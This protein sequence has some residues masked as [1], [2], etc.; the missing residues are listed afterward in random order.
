MLRK[1]TF[2][3]ILAVIILFSAIPLS[4]CGN[5][6][7][8][9]KDSAAPSAFPAAE[10]SEP[11]IET[12]APSAAPTVCP[13]PTSA[14]D[15]PETPT[16]EPGPAYE[17]NPHLYLPILAPE[18]PQ[19]HWDSLYNLCDALRAGETTFECSSEEAYKWATDPVTLVHLF[20]AAALKIKGQSG[21]GSP[22]FE[23]GVGK[24][25][26]QMPAEEFV[27]RQARFEEL[28]ADVL[29]TY[30]EADDNDFEK[31]LKLYDYMESNYTYNYDFIDSMP[32]GHVYYTIMARS[33]QCID[34]GSVY[35]FFLLQAGVEALL[36]SGTAPGM[37]HAW[38]YLVI[39]GNGY[40]SD[41]TWALRAADEPLGLHYFLMS[42][43]LRAEYG[44]DM[45]ELTAPLIP[46]YWVKFSSIELTADND[47]YC[48]PFGSFLV[49]LDE[50][51]KIVRYMLFDE[52]LELCY[53]RN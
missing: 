33:G 35:A 4:G 5:K 17:F 12:A 42:T 51:N 52:E 38:T 7:P 47:E 15:V 22:S 3:L 16:P 26:Y 8:D 34:L 45:D 39:D 10:P 6:T 2:S 29:N 14:E 11:R 30:L 41:P 50:E 49:S 43:E 25:S 37:D 13:S 23:N 48:L 28:V 53:A 21:D 18:I 24:I 27:E 1:K 40:H 31:C 9:G 20:P 44:F 36:V 46:R 32:D 19:D